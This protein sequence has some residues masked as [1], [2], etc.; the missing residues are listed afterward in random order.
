MH[1]GSGPA[2]REAG[3]VPVEAGQVLREIEERLGVLPLYYLFMARDPKYLE[4]VWGR[5]KI[6]MLEGRLPWREKEYLALA[7]SIVNRAPYSISLHREIFRRNGATEDELLEAV[8]V[9]E[10]F[11][12]NN[13]YTTGLN[14]PLGVWERKER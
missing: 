9:V 6:V 8:S 1:T 7:S 4:S 10:V 2:A 5:E 3:A 13:V 11:T 12:K 14:L